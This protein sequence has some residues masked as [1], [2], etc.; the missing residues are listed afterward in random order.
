MQHR[1]DVTINGKSGMKDVYHIN[2]KVM[3]LFARL[4]YDKVFEETVGLP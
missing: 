4:Q 2:W 1:G 3:I